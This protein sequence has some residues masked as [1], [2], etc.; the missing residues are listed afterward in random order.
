MKTLQKPFANILITER[1]KDILRLLNRLKIA[2]SRILRTILSPETSQNTFTSRL[3]KLEE[4]GY[5]QS[6]NPDRSRNQY[7]IYGLTTD[8]HKLKEIESMIGERTE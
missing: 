7:K 6:I 3:L 4:K 5:I 8:S 1:D 2:E